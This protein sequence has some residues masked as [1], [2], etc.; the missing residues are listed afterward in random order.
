[1]RVVDII[2]TKREGRAN[3]DEEISFLVQNYAQDAIPDYQMSAWLMAVVWRGL[4]ETE[5][6]ALTRAM[7]ASGEH[8]DLSSLAG[9]CVDKHST[10]GVGDKTT[11]AVVPIWAAAGIQTPK[12]SGR[13]LGHTGGTLDKLESLGGTRTALGT[14]EILKQVQTIGACL[15]AQTDR[16]VPADRKMYALRDSTDTVE[17]LPLIAA[18]IMSK[19]IAGGCPSIV[20]DVKVGSGAFMKSLPEARALANLMIQIGTASGRKVAA[21][22]SDM[23]IPLGYTVGNRVEVRE[24]VSLLQNNPWIEGRLKTVVLTLAGAGFLLAGRVATLPE[25]EAL[26]EAQIVSRAAFGKLCEIVQ[27][28]GGDAAYLTNGLKPPMAR[29][30]WD[31]KATADGYITQLDAEAIG[32]AAMRL[33]AGRETKDDRIDPAAGVVL[34]ETVGNSVTAGNVIASLFTNNEI[35]A[36]QAAAAVAEAFE[37]GPEPP[38][39][40][41]VIYETIGLDC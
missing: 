7:V 41:P 36:R 14:E 17:S 4:S 2:R 19:K 25:G 27:Y 5:T 40:T 38:V 22:L 3:T 12:M 6:F 31:I 18:S 13:G 10:G 37:I 8:L 20:L 16:L 1:M 23:N 9:P 15:C 28:Q 30:K 26:A 21:V 24:V 29:I 35:A 39:L 34:C 32:L 11:L 33:G